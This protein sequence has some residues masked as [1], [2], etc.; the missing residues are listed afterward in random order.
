M[1]PCKVLEL[2]KIRTIEILDDFVTN[3]TGSRQELAVATGQYRYPMCKQLQDQR[4]PFNLLCLEQI[5]SFTMLHVSP[6][7]R[8]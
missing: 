5:I 8:R 1:F 2:C 4:V 7:S 3:H 6:C